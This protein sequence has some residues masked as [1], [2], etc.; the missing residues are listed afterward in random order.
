MSRLWDLCLKV[1]LV[2][3]LE[4]ASCYRLEAACPNHG[5]FVLKS[6]LLLKGFEQGGGR[7]FRMGNTRTP[8]ADSSQCMAKPT[9]CCKVK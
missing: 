5:F 3:L 7:G 2:L 6:R 1:A 8:M 4:P 9:Q